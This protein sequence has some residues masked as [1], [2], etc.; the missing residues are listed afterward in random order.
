MLLPDFLLTSQVPHSI[1][2]ESTCHSFLSGTP[3]RYSPESQ[4]LLG[5]PVGTACQ[6]QGPL[7]GSACVPYASGSGDGISEIFVFNHNISHFSFRGDHREPAAGG[8]Q[9]FFNFHCGLLVHFKC[10]LN[11]TQALRLLIM[12][13]INWTLRKCSTSWTFVSM[14]TVAPLTGTKVQK[15]KCAKSCGPIWVIHFSPGKSVYFFIEN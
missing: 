6:S 7:T 11:C 14:H 15:L 12:L 2:K 9:S 4:W 8:R 1:T 3:G 10:C 5:L 13:E